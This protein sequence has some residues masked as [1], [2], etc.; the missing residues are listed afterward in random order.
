MELSKGAEVYIDLQK[1]LW[2]DQWKGWQLVKE[3][4]EKYLMDREE[5]LKSMKKKVVKKKALWRKDINS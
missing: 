4:H 1:W 5:K 3:E 2:R